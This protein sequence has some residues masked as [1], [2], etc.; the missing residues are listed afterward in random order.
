MQRTSYFSLSHSTLLLYI[1]CSLFV[2][3]C[4]DDKTTSNQN[5]STTDTAITG[6]TIIQNATKADFYDK[7]RIEATAT[8]FNENTTVY[9]SRINA[10][11]ALEKID[12]THIKN[13]Q[14]VF[15]NISNIEETDFQVLTFSGLTDTENVLFLSETNTVKLAFHKDSLDNRKL[16]GGL[17]NTLF[18]NHIKNIRKYSDSLNHYNLQ[19]FSN[20]QNKQL[21]LQRQNQQRI[22]EIQ[23]EFKSHITNSVTGRPDAVS[24]VI[25][26]TDAAQ[27]KILSASKIISYYKR[28][29][30]YP[31]NTRLGKLLGQSVKNAEAQMLYQQQY[32]AG[33]A[34]GSKA[35]DF[36][37]NTPEGKP[38]NLKK[39][40]LS[41]SK[42]TIVDFWASWC[43]PCR[44]ENPFFVNLYQK[45]KN[46]GLSMV[47][48]SLDRTHASWKNAIKE[49]QLTYPQVSNLKFWQDPIAQSYK[50]RSI[51]ATFVLDATGTVVASGLRGLEL[52]DKIEELLT[53]TPK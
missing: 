31:Q 14:I 46:K 36:T 47:G 22:Q 17:E 39:D 38:L 2:L 15:E 20:R 40:F 26:L 44:Q 52:E 34:Q 16:L 4:K 33:I 48:V 29:E 30:A 28:L 49:D 10:Q 25:A 9:L 24:T 1:S 12:S 13:N 45:Y 50:V 3:S 7:Y 23:Q 11:N 27:T 19:V 21:D 37:A 32:R 51:P 8:G 6:N 18:D 41:K 35:P 5:K 42:Y 43:R 53:T